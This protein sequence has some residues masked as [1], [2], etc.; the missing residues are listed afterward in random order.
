MPIILDNCSLLD[1]FSVV[2]DKDLLLFH[3]PAVPKNFTK[4][5]PY[6]FQSNNS[7]TLLVTLGDSWAWGME[8]SGY[9]DLDNFIVNDWAIV[10]GVISNINK[11]RLTK[12]F[13]NLVSKRIDSDFLNLS[14][15]GHGNFHMAEL[16]SQLA[17]IIPQLNYKKIYVVCT[18]TEVG[19]WF[20]T[21]D[22]LFLDHS[23][24]METVEVTGDV[25]ALLAQLNRMAIDQIINS[26]DK[27]DHVSLLVGTNFVDHVGFE[28]LQPSQILKT[29]WYKLLDISYDFPIYTT[30]GLGLSNFIRSVEDGTVPKRLQ[31]I[32]KEWIINALIGC[33]DFDKKISD[34][35]Y[36]NP[37]NF[38]PI[39]AGHVIWSD[40]V[41]GHII[42]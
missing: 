37:R 8:L 34:S 28:N 10:D 36:F 16:V 13:G 35:S 31:L 29:P 38:H 42:C 3:H 9:N 2:T 15:P 40:Y 14:I 18:L 19:R 5:N 20:N 27:F 32:F 33:E 4:F 21:Q 7:D 26:V 11:D 41:A 24:L 39:A 6:S 22:D 30:Y 17:N 25:N 23:K 1:Y 12:V